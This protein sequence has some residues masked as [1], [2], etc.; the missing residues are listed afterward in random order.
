[1]GGGVGGWRGGGMG[2]EVMGGGGFMGSEP[3]PFFDR[4][5]IVPSNS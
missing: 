3:L 1:M 2:G 4:V 5:Q